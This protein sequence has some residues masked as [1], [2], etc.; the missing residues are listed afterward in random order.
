MDGKEKMELIVDGK[1]NYEEVNE[2]VIRNLIYVVR[3]QQVM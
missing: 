1:E 2:N 3:G